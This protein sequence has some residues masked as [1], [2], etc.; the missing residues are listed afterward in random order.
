MRTFATSLLLASLVLAQSGELKDGKLTE[1]AWNFTYEAP[2]LER[3]LSTQDPDVIFTGRAAGRLQIEL[4]VLEGAEKRD[5]KTWM[6]QQQKELKK[7]EPK[8][9]GLETHT[10]G[11]AWL[12]FTVPKLGALVEQHGYAFLPRGTQCFVVH[13]S[14]A[15]KTETSTD[16]IK[17]AIAG[18]KLGED[19][20]ASVLAIQ[21][22][23]QMGLP[24][25]H[26]LV[27]LQ[28]GYLYASPP[29][30]HKPNYP[31]AAKVLTKARAVMKEDSFNAEQLYFLYETGGLA[32]LSEPLRDAKTAID[33]HTKAEEAAGK[34]SEEQGRVQRKAQSAYNLACAY[35]LAG[36]VDQGFAALHRAFADVMTVSKGHLESDRDLD[37]LKKNSKLWDKFW[38]ECVEGR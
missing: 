16:A 10:D 25:D 30:P 8:L 11:G 31:M 36:D 14:V 19:P 4:I 33:W 26:P 20:G 12:M 34:L 29:E 38:K 7:D 13:A 6:E 15:D 22:S 5:A 18:L 21:A 27:L 17:A 28:A 32:Y 23:Q 35:S 24:V 3:T 1:K 2:G 9:T 37:N